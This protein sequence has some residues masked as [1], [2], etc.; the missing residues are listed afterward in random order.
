MF[1]KPR[2]RWSGHYTKKKTTANKSE[3]Y[4]HCAKNNDL[5]RV[6]VRLFIVCD[7]VVSILFSY[8]SPKTSQHSTEMPCCCCF[9]FFFCMRWNFVWFFLSISQH[10]VKHLTFKFQTVFHFYIFFSLLSRLNIC[11]LPLAW[12]ISTII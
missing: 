8:F 2:K 1:K 12:T 6:R 11:E 4:V 7:D 3:K 5:M 10:L 9:F